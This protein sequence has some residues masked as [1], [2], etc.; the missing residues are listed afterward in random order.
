[1]TQPD[2][3]LEANA[4]E[5][6]AGA[7]PETH[8]ANR[9]PSDITREYASPAIRVQW[10][11]SRCIHS[12]ACIRAL[13][14]VFDPTRRPWVDVNAANA[15]AIASAVV[16]CP[17][18]ALHFHRTDGGPQESA[19]AEV[20]VVAV[21]NGPYLLTGP[22]QVTDSRGQIV[23]ED[24]RVALCRCGQSKHMPFCDNTHR[25]IGFRAP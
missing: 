6:G 17:T 11:A 21:R 20:R 9:L 3:G 24:T 8:E 14:E 15:D 25:A 7:P 1:M 22:V 23:R 5:G 13:P 18:G 2:A 16:K 4:G 12:A 19:G 10:H